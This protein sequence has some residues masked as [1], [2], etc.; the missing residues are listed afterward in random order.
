[1]LKATRVLLAAILTILI[2]LT[3]IQYV[4]AQDTPTRQVYAYYMGWWTGEAW[5]DTTLSDRAAETYDSRD[6]SALGRHIDQA[7]GAGIDAFIVSWFGPEGDNLTNVAFN[8]LLDQAAG[9]GFQIGV[10]VDM[11][12]C[13][14][15]N[16]VDSV[17]AALNHIINDRANHPAYLRYNGKPVIYFWNQGR[18]SVDT[19]NTL[20][21]EID[22]NHNTIWVMEGTGT[23]YL[24]VFDGLYLFN[25][26]WGNPSSVAS[27]WA[28]RARTSGATFYTPTVMPGWNEDA[29]AV[30][31]NRANPSGVV[32]RG[33]GDYLTRS[34]NGAVASGA[35]TIMIVSWNE[36]FE[37][38]HIEPSQN[39]DTVALDTLRPLIQAWKTPAQNN[40]GSAAVSGAPSGLTFTVS[41]TVNM[42]GAP[43]TDG[44]LVA[45]IPFGT[46]VEV[47]ARNSD[48]SWLLVNSGGNSG[49]VASYLGTLKG[50]VNSLP[51]R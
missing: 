14:Y 16:S 51:A 44:A 22:P 20:R 7:R 37:N 12:Q 19:W 23:G 25:V 15:L 30:R 40:E 17:K 9:R 1:M 24:K 41:Y 21:G 45:K 29:V 6:G 49:W 50:D 4:V 28:N 38:S 13:D 26:S 33:A 27:D 48:A 3:A 47:V 10:S 36:Y 43:S 5:G 46:A 42:R 35:N 2:A 11:F 32:E 34:W 39:F 8:T 31:D 18:F